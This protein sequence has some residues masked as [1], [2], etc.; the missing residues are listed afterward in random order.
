MGAKQSKRPKANKISSDMLEAECLKLA[1]LKSKNQARKL[2][3]SE[4]EICRTWAQN[5][6]DRVRSRRDSHTQTEPSSSDCRSDLTPAVIV[7]ETREER[8][9]RKYVKFQE[10]L[11]IFYQNR[12]KAK[13]LKLHQE[14]RTVVVKVG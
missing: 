8:K 10:R 3:Q 2:S 1:N 5:A 14:A 7:T 12:L 11:E 9:A 13:F 4:R 6:R